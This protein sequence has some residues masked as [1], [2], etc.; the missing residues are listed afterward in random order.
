MKNF[1]TIVLLAFL[2]ACSSTPVLPPTSTISRVAF[3]KE[4]TAQK[5][6]AITVD[7]K[8]K[9]YLV[10]KEGNV[11]ILS[12]EGEKTT[13]LPRIT[14]AG[15]KILKRPTDV[16]VYKDK[17]F[18]TDS[19]LDQVSIFTVDGVYID[20]FGESGGSPKE[21]N[22]PKGIQVFDGVIYVAD[23]G[24]NRIQV[25][26][27]NGV[28]LHSITGQTENHKETP[29]ANLISKPAGL[30]ID[31]LGQLYVI[32]ASDRTVKIYNP[33]GEFID[34]IADGMSPGSII[35]DKNGFF[36]TDLKG[37]SIRKYGFDR[38]LLFSFGTKGE[39][40]AQFA[41]IS[42]LSKDA[43]GNI[44]V[45]DQKRSLIQVFS[46]EK[47]KDSYPG[48]GFNTPPPT[49]VQWFKNIA[50]TRDITNAAWN[51]KDTIYAVDGKNIY[52]IKNGTTKQTITIKDCSPQ[53]VA[54]DKKGSLW[55]LDGRK[56]RVLKLDE[57]GKILSSF[58]SPGSG[59][60]KL[61]K[62][63][64]MAIAS[65]GII[66]V[67]DPGNR[68]V[69][70][71]N[72]DGVFLN[73]IRG[74]NNGVSLLKPTA[75]FLNSSDMLH[76]LDTDLYAVLTYSSKGE[77]I[78]QFGKAGKNEYDF[79]K[80]TDLFASEN[81][82]FVLDAGTNNVK[83]FTHEGNFIRSF[84]TKGNSKGDFF[85]SV[86]IT[87]KDSNHFFVV[88]S[89]NERIQTLATIYTPPAPADVKARNEMRAVTLTWKPCSAPFVTG[90]HIY[91]SDNKDGPF[92]LLTTVKETLYEDRKVS[93]GK[94]YFYA[95]TAMA[96]DGNES[97]AGSIVSSIPSCYLP[98]PPAKLTAEAHEWSVSLNWEPGKTEYISHYTVFREQNGVF[99]E[100]GKSE[101]PS[102]TDTSLRP[103]TS[104][105]YKVTAVSSDAK[106][107]EAS[108]I[109][110]TTK[111]AQKQPVGIEVPEIADIFSNTYKV[112]EKEGMGR[113]IIT[114]NTG[115]T[116]PRINISFT[117]KEFMDFP[118][119]MEIKDLQPGAGKDLSLKAVF[120]NKILNV[121]EDT[122]VQTEIRAFYYENNQLHNFS[123][124]LP[125]NI[126]EKHRMMWDV[127][128]RFATFI[129]PKDP[130]V[131]EFTRSIVTQFKDADNALQQ[132]AV[133][134]AAMGNS[135]LIY[136]QDP[137]NPYQITSGKTDLI[138]YVQYPH[139]T[140]QRKSG[141]CDDLVALYAASLE[142][143]GIKTKAI[144]V[145]GHMLMMFS[146][147]IE[148]G[149]QRETM[150]DLF[151]IHDNFMWVPIE[152]TMVGSS[153][154]KAWGQ[155]SK[156]Y[157]KWLDKNLSLLD[158]RQAWRKFK[159]ASLPAS[160]W[161]LPA[162]SRKTL[163][164]DFI[165]EFK[166]LKRI[167]L[168]LH[169]Q[170]Y[171]AILV[172]NPKDID[173]LMQI[174]IIYGR[175]EE[176]S[177]SRTS[178]EKVLTIDPNHVSA[179]NNLGNIYYLEQ[180]YIKAQQTYEKAAEIEPNDPLILV[181]LAKCYHQQNMIQKASLAFNKARKMAP[182]IIKKYRALTLELSTDL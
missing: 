81:E 169:T 15:V 116:I 150:D 138:D 4:I 133:I 114:N 155:G 82:I 54:V 93:P 164:D 53:A 10:D 99:E 160:N 80:P 92:S 65:N 151:V 125:V 159:P 57:T 2:T 143:L 41:S 179:M 128:E 91:K 44:Y 110:V 109:K 27:P 149:E 145:P 42:G 33:H 69:Q 67:A 181:N 45:A 100:I 90:Y 19:G 108:A 85:K 16:A 148:A 146:T 9:I 168:N 147:N 96:K 11:S 131:L 37:L 153:F 171:R 21:F 124:N 134:F 23:T 64:D 22:N 46:P 176:L 50:V 74:G 165:N 117:I 20:S 178:F 119:E 170:K 30:A 8:G 144:E 121:T 102:F 58:G 77:P 56:K 43:V 59:P 79:D 68:M 175:A 66:Y 174:G 162:V 52:E 180:N 12:P 141:D 106:E 14:S 105:S 60:G 72:K 107:G 5:P 163:G 152:T 167:G 25:F 61:S 135:G 122:P 47:E 166:N 40:R 48:G 13:T 1:A 73:V 161:R 63:T 95:I 98:A 89:G 101:I 157:Y 129:T 177:R 118:S 154:M 127:R 120:N 18:V 156:T 24:N 84:G 112:Y 103:N 17:I 75:L 28:Y 173:A 32:D 26:G 49:S 6:L 71:F 182:D 3:I 104:Y 70:V 51:G 87:P 78:A 115:I 142:S 126:Y 35:M 62:P 39:G 136:M 97:A 140:L 29:A 158:I 88:D 132:A 123:K 139:E 31:H 34:Q 94:P 76:V 130:V 172:A 113:I 36:V 137:S 38:K 83:V 7:R 55:A 86:S 111:I